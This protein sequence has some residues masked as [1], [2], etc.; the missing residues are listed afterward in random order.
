MDKI[1]VIGAGGQLGTELVLKL[2]ESY[3]TDNV[4]AT[5]IR[6]LAGEL[7]EGP[8]EK[9]NIL[10]VDQYTSILKRHGI[11]QVYHL[12]A[13]LSAKGESD[14]LFAWKLNM[15]S[16]LTVLESGR[17]QIK[18][19]YWPS[20]IAVFGPDTPADNTP[21]NTIMNPSTVYGISKLAGERWC[22]YY[23][24]KYGVDVRSIRYPGLIGYKAKP[25]G[26]TTDYAVDVFWKAVEG[27]NFECFLKPDT[28]LPMMYMEDAIRGTLELMESPSENIKV[29]SSYNFSGISFTPEELFREVAKQF[30][31]MEFSYSPDFRQ[32]IADSWPNSIDDSAAQTDWNWKPEF[33]L[34]K[35]TSEM[36]AGLKS[37]LVTN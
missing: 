26:G 7:A 21:Q 2:R 29:R 11:T 23:F 16:L 32:K 6:D 5:D 25:G 12:A 28:R 19:I 13:V 18:K 9:L 17:D 3:G 10:E 24:Q 33:D 14:P 1:L 8:H 36:I 30:P 31:E 27:E 22:E 15:E 34:S 20:S 37:Q 35:M 4:L